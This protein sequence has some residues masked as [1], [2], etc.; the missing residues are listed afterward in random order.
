MNTL[1]RDKYPFLPKDARTLFKM[2]FKVETR[3]I[4]GHKSVI[5]DPKKIMNLFL[6]EYKKDFLL[7][8]SITLTLNLDGVSPF[9]S[10]SKSFWS[11]L[12]KINDLHRNIIFPVCLTF[13]RGKPDNLEFLEEPLNKLN[14]LMSEGREI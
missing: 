5:F 12:C 1:L 11:L 6:K 10:S 2:P 7:P 4:S 3:D 8:S 13:G 14:L 9:K